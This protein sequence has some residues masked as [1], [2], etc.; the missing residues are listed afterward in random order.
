MRRGG[1]G[2]EVI[3]LIFIIF[4][5]EGGHMLF[6]WPESVGGG[7]GGATYRNF[8]S[9]FSKKFF[10]LPLYIKNNQSLRRKSYRMINI[11]HQRVLLG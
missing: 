5:K 4:I 9:K 3:A 1:E 6:T 7:G 11:S 10:L 2:R 8:D